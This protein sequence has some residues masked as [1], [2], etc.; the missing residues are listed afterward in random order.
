MRD[1]FLGGTFGAFGCQCFFVG[2]RKS[3]WTWC[4][5]DVGAESGI[6][7]GG[8]LVNASSNVSLSSFSF[9]SFPALNFNPFSIIRACAPSFVAGR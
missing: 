3:R 9:V 1:M 6:F 4:V 8:N 2:G 5:F 7:V